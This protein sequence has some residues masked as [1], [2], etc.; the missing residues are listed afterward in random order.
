MRYSLSHFPKISV[1]TPSF[2]QGRFIGET[3][4]SIRAQRYP[5]LELIIM[6]GGSSDETASVVSSFGSLVTHFTSEPDRGQS[7]AINKGLKMATGDILCWLNSDDVYLHGALNAVA[8]AFCS[9]PEW[10]WISGPSLKFGDALHSLDGKYELPRSRVEWLLHCPITQP[11]TFW[12]RRLYEEHGGIDESFNF[13]LDYEYWARFIFSGESLHFLNRPLSGYRLHDESKTVA[14]SEE[15]ASEEERIREKYDPKM[16]ASERV[17]LA[18]RLSYLSEMDGLAL[19]VALLE[20]GQ[21]V[22]ARKQV[23]T[24]L[25]HMPTLMFTQT[26]AASLARVLLNKPRYR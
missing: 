3:L 18:R 5:D 16:L 15:F 8:H 17:E 6:D 13:A 20:E 24:I 19:A 10:D 1:I 23:L 26:G 9:N 22:E 2:N 12:R 21:V 14:L 25:S 11:S 7:H 4:E